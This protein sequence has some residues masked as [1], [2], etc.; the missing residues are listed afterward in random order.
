MTS[1]F[2]I[3]RHGNT[4]ASGE[5]PRRIG[6]R[7][8]LPLVESGRVQAEQLA[9][10]LVAQHIRFDRMLCSPLR[11]TR[12]T[13]QILLAAQSGGPAIESSDLLAEIDHGVDENRSE[14]EVIARIGAEALADWDSKGLVPP[15]WTV[16]G[17]ARLARWAALLADPAPA[18]TVLITSNGAARFALMADP[19]LAAQAAALPSLKL[20]TGAFGMITVDSGIPVLQAW[21]RRP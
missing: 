20:R 21:D 7:T 10:W 5:T 12:E 2:V 18:T 9:Q 1:R 16:D 8:D 11:R 3:V 15:G 17:E 19:R 6:A 4:F 13:A 14:A